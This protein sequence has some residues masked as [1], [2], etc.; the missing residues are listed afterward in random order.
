VAD[1]VKNRNKRSFSD[2]EELTD[3]ILEQ[4]REL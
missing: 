4:I 2:E 3:I 1:M